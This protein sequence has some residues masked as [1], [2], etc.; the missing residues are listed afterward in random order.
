[1]HAHVIFLNDNAEAVFIGD[2]AEAI[3]EKERRAAAHLVKYPESRHY[4][5]CWHIKTRPIV[6]QPEKLDVAVSELA[7]LPRRFESVNEGY[8]TRFKTM[9]REV[10]LAFLGDAP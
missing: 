6:V 4:M 10:L 3:A 2:E 8:E 1:M 7:T 9:V 5:T